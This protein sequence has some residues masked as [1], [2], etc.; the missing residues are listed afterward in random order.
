MS[1]TSAPERIA[2]CT[3]GCYRRRCSDAPGRALS[4]EVAVDDP[5][6]GPCRALPLLSDVILRAIPPSALPLRLRG[7]GPRRAR[8][9]GEPGDTAVDEV[10]K[11]TLRVPEIPADVPVCAGQPSLNLPNASWAAWLSANAYVDLAV[12]APA[13]DRTPFGRPGDGASWLSG[14]QSHSVGPP[15]SGSCSARWIEA[16]TSHRSRSR[17][18]LRA[19]PSPAATSGHRRLP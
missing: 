6:R 12:V 5:V 2:S 10:A 18:Q 15:C 1:R 11:R 7:C 4:S 13:I 14:R 3:R 17:G 16:S 19:L 8:R 9:Y